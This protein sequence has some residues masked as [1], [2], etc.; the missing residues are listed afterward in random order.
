MRNFIAIFA[1][2]DGTT[3]DILDIY[4]RRITISIPKGSLFI[5]RGIFIHAGYYDINNINYN[6]KY[7]FLSNNNNNNNNYY[8]SY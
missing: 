1:I 3:I 2:E 8:Y 4:N 6:N 7:N 5:A